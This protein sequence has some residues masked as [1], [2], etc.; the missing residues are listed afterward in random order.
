MAN[1]TEKII[2]QTLLLLLEEKALDKITVKDIVET[3][4]I[5]RNTFYYHF[6][7]IPAALSWALNQEIEEHLGQAKPSSVSD[8]FLEAIDYIE[9]HRKIMYHIYR[10][11]HRET[12][13]M[14]ARDFVSHSLMRY[15]K[16]SLSVS[17][18]FPSEEV[19]LIRYFLQC[20]FIGMVIDWMENQMRYDLKGKVKELL[21]FIKRSEYL[22]D[23][24]SQAILS[25]S[26]QKQMSPSDS[27]E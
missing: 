4:G 5:N 18:A 23:N 17:P 11:V 14:Y 22:L 9:Q 10:S 16:D 1:Q 24:K 3:C 7:D 2:T 6:A 15:E 19:E 25:S 21:S 27:I 12:L 26:P 20:F 13:I 8:S